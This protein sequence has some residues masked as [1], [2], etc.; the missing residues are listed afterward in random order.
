[1]VVL[2][3][4]CGF[5]RNDWAG[6]TVVT[7]EAGVERYAG[8]L[9]RTGCLMVGKLELGSQADGEVIREEAPAW[10]QGAGLRA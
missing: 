8:L 10:P 2:P 5:R 1:M 7:P 9:S 3:P 6:V 4:V